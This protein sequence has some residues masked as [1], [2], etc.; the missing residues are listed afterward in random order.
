M[1][2]D[3]IKNYSFKYMLCFAINK[4]SEQIYNK[5]NGLE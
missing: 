2:V 3:S 5:L 1:L 4:Q